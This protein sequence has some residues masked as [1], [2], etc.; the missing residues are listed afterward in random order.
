MHAVANMSHVIPNHVLRVG[1]TVR[2]DSSP[3]T[4]SPSPSPSPCHPNSSTPFSDP[5][6]EISL[7]NLNQL[8]LDLDPTFEPLPITR[9]PVSV[10]SYTGEATNKT[11]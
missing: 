10:S 9:S 11:V 1:Q 4:T 5:E 2:Q 6:L 8:I 7:D 3:R